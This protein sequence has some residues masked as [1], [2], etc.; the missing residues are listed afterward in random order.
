MAN[1]PS[2]PRP[3]TAGNNMSAL[4][5]NPMLALLSATFPDATSDDLTQSAI[6]LCEALSPLQR[7]GADVVSADIFT[8]DRCDGPASYDESD[9]MQE[10]RT[11]PGS[12]F[13]GASCRG[14]ASNYNA[15]D[16]SQAGK[17]HTRN[18]AHNEGDP[19]S[20]VV[21]HQKMQHHLNHGGAQQYS[22]NTTSHQLSGI[23]RLSGQL[24][25]YGT[26]AS[27]VLFSEL[28]FK[29]DSRLASATP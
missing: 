15:S 23:T 26:R 29:F 4:G 22:P 16:I 19:V 5:S 12:N 28:K 17:L 10:N 2:S 18:R 24:L 8:M 25:Q 14:F 11:T 13:S 3:Q 27:C 7:V 21:L 6:D 9:G 1:A 20:P